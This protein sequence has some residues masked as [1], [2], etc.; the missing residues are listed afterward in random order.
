MIGHVLDNLA[1]QDPR[2]NI[3]KEDI[4]KR[5]RL[6]RSSFKTSQSDPTIV[7]CNPCVTKS[8]G[9]RDLPYILSFKLNEGKLEPSPSKHAVEK[10]DLQVVLAINQFEIYADNVMYARI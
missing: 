9:L 1:K 7:F 6:G 8:D 10:I 4:G 3:D 2:Y 5:V